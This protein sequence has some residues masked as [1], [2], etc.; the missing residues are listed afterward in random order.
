MKKIFVLIMILVITLFNIETHAYIA[1]KIDL[2]LNDNETSIV[3]L[4]LYHS[5]SLLII[6]DTSSH[7]FILDY[8]K[9]EGI[10]EVLNIFNTNPNIHFLQN[11]ID[12]KI[13]NIYTYKQKNLLKFRVNNY[14]LCIYKEVSDIKNCDFVYL[15]DLKEEFIMNENVSAI[16]YDEK[17]KDNLLAQV[18]ESWID[19]YIVSP[20]SFTIL[21][22]NEESYNI[23][24]IPSTKP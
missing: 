3:F 20:K 4:R 8:R 15:M 14:T 7:L 13:D 6:S 16:F 17:I 12:K 23:A 9:D 11:K 24:I 21:K 2:K 18:R 10:K 1:K 19:N 5:N 22:I